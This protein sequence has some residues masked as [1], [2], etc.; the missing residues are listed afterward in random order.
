MQALEGEGFRIPEN[1]KK[2]RS[3]LRGDKHY[4]QIALKVKQ[5]QLEIGASGV[6]R[7]A[8]SVFRDHD[9]DFLAYFDKMPADKRD[10]LD[11][12]AHAGE[13]RSAA[14]QRDYYLDDWRTWQM[15]D[16]LPM[17]VQLKVDFT[18]AYLGSLT[19]GQQPLSG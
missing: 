10:F 15:S 12:G 16:H 4:D 18:D 5:K 3:N 11:R 19:P 14:E 7:F 13:R 17:W 8:Q 6:F 9:D 2:E 1:L